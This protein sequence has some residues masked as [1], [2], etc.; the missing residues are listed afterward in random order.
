VSAGTVVFVTGLPSSGKSTFAERA[1]A[2]L[3]RHTPAV[4]V[5][6]G[7]ALRASLIPGHDYTP[8]GRADVYATLARVAALLAKQELIVLVA[9][10]AHLRAYRALA[11]E[12]APAFLEV[13]VDTPLGECERRDTKG[14]YAASRSGAAQFLPGAGE[15]YE[16]PLA[17]DLVA[18]GG[19]DELA[20]ARLA[21]ELAAKLGRGT[22]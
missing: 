18:H 11:R 15:E 12:L 9:A 17:P 4:C 22:R 7:D 2:A 6:D 13:W 19:D 21:H 14:L 8:A 5:L 10:T 3:R 16:P 20:V 1:A